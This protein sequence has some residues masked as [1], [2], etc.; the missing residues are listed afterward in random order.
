MRLL[1]FEAKPRLA[2]HGIVV[3][4][5]ALWPSFP[6]G[7]TR[8]VVKAQ[9]P[10]GGRGKRGAVVLD[11]DR[12]D[13]ASVATGL[14]GQRLGADVVSHVYVEEQLDIARE[15]Y[16]SVSVDR[17]ERRLIIL[18]ALDGG[19][20]VESA[21]PDRRLQ[22]PIDPLVGLRPFHIR[23]LARFLEVPDASREWF[24]ATVTALCRA[25]TSEDALLIEIN[26][27]VLTTRGRW[28]AADAKMV[29]DDNADFRH[30]D[31]RMLV[32]AEEGSTIDR[33]I[34][35]AGATGIEVDPR[36]TLVG[37][38]SG[39]GLMMATLDFLS[40]AG[41]PVRYM[42]D[43]G[44]TPLADPRGLVP[45]FAAV[46]ELQPAVVFVNAYFQTA[47]A[48]GF[49]AALLDAHAANPIRGRVIVRL[50]GRNASRAHALLAPHGFE[51]RSELEEGLLAALHAATGVNPA[52]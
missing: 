21:P 32:L 47:L 42:I 22:L 7:A 31:W 50:K 8:Y 36:G 9:V 19:I 33:R 39:A 46:S 28:V 5:G 51:L 38:V 25:A 30:P 2:R 10:G 12:S 14:L 40:A 20:D 41:A 18:G 4:S 6:D 48:D 24:D 35:A 29:V 15:V 1:E 3:P 17:D 27:L 34:A 44:G 13:I 52:G 16:L 26:P 11:T 45:I 23:R 37:V 43:L 49:A